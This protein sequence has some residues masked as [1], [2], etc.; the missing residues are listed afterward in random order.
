ME[1]PL[2][3]L[4]LAVIGWI[5]FDSMR[6]REAAN[7]ACRDECGRLGVQ[8]LNGTV[9]LESLD[10][11]RDGH[12]RR[13]LRRTYGF[14]FSGTGLER[15]HGRVVVLGKHVTGLHLDHASCSSE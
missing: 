14:E 1:A 8:F 15:R 6:A 13:R 10:L 7:R 11:G 3:F 2:A 9:A 5:W 12:G 4:I